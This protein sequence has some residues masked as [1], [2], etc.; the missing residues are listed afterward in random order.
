MLLYSNKFVLHWY[1]EFW[2]RGLFRLVPTSLDNWGSTVNNKHLFDIPFID[3]S[4]T[5]FISIDATYSTGLG[6]LVNDSPR[7]R[8][9]A[10]MKKI[11][12]DN[13]TYLCLFATCNIP[14]STE[15]RYDYGASDL[16]WR[17]KG[18][19]KQLHSSN[20]KNMKVITYQLWGI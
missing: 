18:T 13:Q 16:H 5:I 20:C 10:T 1:S 14:S 4:T 7:A 12:I 2:L 17:T 3:K 11:V 6:R 19:N 9:N 15:L 8:A